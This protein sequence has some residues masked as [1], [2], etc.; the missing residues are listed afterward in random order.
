M[1][2]LHEYLCRQAEALLR[3]R[4]VVVF[5][6]PRREFAPF[7]AELS[8]TGTAAGK[9]RRVPIGALT[10]TLAEYTGS[11]FEL[12]ADVEELAGRDR[13]DPLV[14]YVPGVTRDPVNSVL[15]ELEQAG[16][17]R[18]WSLKSLARNLL[19]K[20]F[21]DGLLRKTF[22]D[23][24]IDELLG[25]G[26][27]TYQ[28]VVSF[29][30][31]AEE[32]ET[33]SALRGLFG[34]QRSEPLIAGWLASTEA[35]NDITA[36]NVRSELFKLIESRI[37][38]VLPADTSL[39]AARER[40]AR[41]VL[42]GDFRVAL[43]GEPP[44]SIA[45]LPAA[46]TE[47][48]RER[49]AEITR[50]LRRDEPDQYAA[51]AGRVEHDM[52]LRD[53]AIAPAQLGSVATFAFEER[54]LLGH[55]GE[56]IAEKAYGEALDVILARRRSFWVDRDVARQA[57]W[58]ASRLMVTLG[59]AILE[60]RAALPKTGSDP[61]AWVKAYT[62][63]GGWHEIDRL[64][65]SLETWVGKMDEEPEHAQAFAVIRREHEEL[66]KLMANGFGKAFQSAGWAVAG[67]LHQTSIYPQVVEPSPGPVAYFFV[68]A[69][70]F[71][72][73][74]ELAQRLQGASELS[75][76]PAIAALPS[77]TPVGMARAPA[78]RIGELLRRRG[79]PPAGVAH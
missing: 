30:Q 22:S 57:Q 2:A 49:V 61:A 24:R 31:Q 3:R 62:A 29:L 50:L 51:L 18:E 26:T 59:V 77:I 15:M 67:I 25:P 7:F 58:E 55:I 1:H 48:Q 35:D 20:T 16:Q 6:D 79:A 11:F 74:A 36:K 56:L 43:T 39:A 21:S 45:R 8:A 38:L 52:H 69:M 72:M 9:L 54:R 5:Y 46:Q 53:E 47:Q 66:L 14:L 44:Q 75:L 4:S 28:D 34:N 42:L 27:A 19:R 17:H 64:H 68:D 37:G 13:P 65:R 40:V 41:Y 71:E 60:A 23:G 78:G 73:G 70:R 63:D 32:V 33:P 12:R 10:V 76:R